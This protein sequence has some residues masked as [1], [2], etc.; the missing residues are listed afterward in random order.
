M[1]ERTRTMKL[2]HTIVLNLKARARRLAEEYEAECAEDYRQGHRPHYCR[3]G[4][5][6]WTDYDNICGSCENGD[7][8]LDVYYEALALAKKY[9]HDLDKVQR[10]YTLL[11]EAAPQVASK[12]PLGLA[13][14]VLNWRAGLAPFPKGI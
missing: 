3:H 6:Q 10:S 12:F 11:V 13:V 7:S 9:M 4:T 2:A 14:D 8:A 5:N 1:N